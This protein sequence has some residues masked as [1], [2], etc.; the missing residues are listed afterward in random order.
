MRYLSLVV[1]VFFFGCAQVTSLNLQKHQFGRIPTKIV[2]IQIAG[3]AP[4]HLALL[5]FSNDG[6]NRNTAFE[7]SICIGSM[8]NY[9]LYDL[10]PNA[11]KGFKAQL[12]GKK[13]LKNSCEDFRHKPIWKYLTSQNYKVGLFES[14]NMEKQSLTASNSCE[15]NDDFLDE[16]VVWRMTTN[17]K[18]K[19]TFHVNEKKNY[20]P[21]IIYD[22]KACLSGE[23]FTS[24]SR[25]VEATYGEFTRNTKNYLYILQNYNYQNLLKKNKIQQART[26]LLEL[27][28]VIRFFQKEAEKSSDMLVL[29]T[30]S[31]ATSLKLP[32]A[33]HQWKVYEKSAKYVRVDPSLLMSPTYAFGAR[34]ENFCGI[35]EQNQALMRI[36]SGAKQQG[37]EFSIIN[38]FE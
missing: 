33:G 6:R 35:Y 25:N 34:A 10:R 4:E 8:W 17:K 11:F 22:D 7:N 20:E 2:W 5:K 14:L 38:P 36:F 30:S 21:G 27:N 37:L 31:D 26:E 1:F 18:T 15:N 28:S 12:T 24:L 29:V 3:L 16:L 13:D 32:K 23:C 19:N 9:D